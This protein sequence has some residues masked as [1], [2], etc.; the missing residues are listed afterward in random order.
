MPSPS[1]GASVKGPGSTTF[2]DPL[3][4]RAGAHEGTSSGCLTYSGFTGGE[5]ALPTGRAC[6]SWPSAC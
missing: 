1:A 3:F 6:A 2:D 4:A 5:A